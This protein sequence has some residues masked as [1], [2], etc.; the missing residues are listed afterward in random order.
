MSA[1]VRRRRRRIFGQAD[2]ERVRVQV[3]EAQ[4][5]VQVAITLSGYNGKS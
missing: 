2:I 3:H 5:R 1:L 4:Q